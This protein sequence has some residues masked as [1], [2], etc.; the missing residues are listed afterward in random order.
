MRNLNRFGW[1]VA[2]LSVSLA[3]YGY[4]AGNTADI[5]T[6]GGWIRASAPGQDQA[7]ADLSITSRQSAT[8]IGA[9]SPACKTVQLHTMTME[10]GMMRMREVKAIELPAGKQVN[11]RD[12]GYH[13]MMIG[14]KAPLKEGETV[15]LTLSIRPGKGGVV[16]IRTVAE[17]RSL[18]GAHS[19]VTGHQQMNMQMY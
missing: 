13:L 17:V 9:S 18:T 12:S 2:A 11:L 10:G 16:K 5:E 3:S 7:G 1:L 4:A 8:L 6:G 15:P 14:L 19:R